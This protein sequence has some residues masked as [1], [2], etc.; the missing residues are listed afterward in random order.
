MV[1]ERTDK[2]SEGTGLLT[3]P[4][5]Q[6]SPPRGPKL[7]QGFAMKIGHQNC[8][9]GQPS[10]QQQHTHTDT[11][12]H[13]RTHTHTH[14]HLSGDG[15]SIRQKLCKFLIAKDV[16]QCGLGHIVCRGTGVLNVE[17][18]HNWVTDAKEDHCI[19]FDCDA[20]LGQNLEREVQKGEEE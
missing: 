1:N 12:T 5:S 18:G 4:P 17:D 7:H 11:H 9:N 3:F 15:L 13:T 8:Y 14:L 19:Y 2:Q 6:P 16:P 10:Q 20:V